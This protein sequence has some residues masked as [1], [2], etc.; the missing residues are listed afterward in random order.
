MNTNKIYE[1]Y[2]EII[3][4]NPKLYS[5][6]YEKM[7]MEVANSSAIYKNKPVPHLYQGLFYDKI[8]EDKFSEISNILMNITKKVTNEYISNFKYRE[9]FN[10]SKE[11]EELILTDPGY[12]FPVPMARYDMFFGDGD[13]KFVEFN[14]DGSS[15]MNEDNTIG[16]ILLDKL[17][18]KELS[19]KYKLEIVDLFTPWIKKST[20]FYEKKFNKKPNVAIV[21]LLD[22]GTSYEFKEFKKRYNELGYNC[23]ICDI[24]NLTYSNGSLYHKDYKIDLVYRRV[25]TVEFMKHYNELTDF[26][27]AYK[28]NAFL[29][30]GSFRSQMMH[31]KLSFYVLHHEMTKS[32]LDP[33]ENEFIKNHIPYTDILDSSNSSLV[34]SNK[35]KYIIKPVDDYSSHGIYAGID[36]NTDEWSNIINKYKDTGYIYQDYNYSPLYDFVTFEDDK[37]LL[38]KYGAVFGMF[39]Y[40]GEFIGLYTRIGEKSTIGGSENYYT[41][42]NILVSEK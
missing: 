40:F 33:M 29:M 24:R 10:F 28:D 39:I 13:F 30:L 23:E 37:A 9:L 25:V 1:E 2:F 17:A 22:I 18:M 3:K 32:I 35:D 11:L 5:Q 15:A 14:T 8:Y 27:Q 26:I 4:K 42:P 19:K 36:H 12:D 7:K 16:N 31:T 21:D 34:I 41:A 20:S 6:D 38:K